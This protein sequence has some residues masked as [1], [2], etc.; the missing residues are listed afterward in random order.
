MEEK[1]SSH[2][3]G[4]MI[5]ERK[6]L[7]EEREEY[8][9]GC[10]VVA[11]AP[12]SFFWVGEHSVMY[13]QPALIQTIPIYVYVG[14]EISSG[15]DFDAEIRFV[16]WT[17]STGFGI[18]SAKGMQP[19][20]T[21]SCWQEWP[22]I[23]EFLTYWADNSKALNIR[24]A[25]KVW[26]EIPPKCGLNSS[27]AISSALAL[28]LKLLE[29]QLKSDPGLFKIKS[30]ISKWHASEIR[31]LK[32]DPLFNEL[33]LTAWVL[34]DCFHFFS[35]SGMGP[36][37]SL[38]GS[39]VQR[40]LI[41]FI[42][43]QKGY[44]SLLPIKRL[45]L[46]KIRLRPAHFSEVQKK[47]SAIQYWGNR[48]NLSPYMTE[49][50]GICALYTGD[51]KDTGKLLEE[52]E[53][54][55]KVTDEELSK[56]VDEAFDGQLRINEGWETLSAP[57]G[58]LL[59]PKEEPEDHPEYYSK[60][61][62]NQPNGLLAIYMLKAL[63]EE[64]VD[65]IADAVNKT[66]DFLRFYGA[67]T[68]R[69]E[70]I[71]TKILK[72]CEGNIG[73]KLTGAGGGGDLIV[74]GER[75][76]VESFANR[77]RNEYA[78]HYVTGRFPWAASVGIDKLNFSKFKKGGKELF[79]IILAGKLM[80]VD[81]AQM[82]SLKKDPSFLLFVDSVEGEIYSKG[83]KVYSKS[84]LLIPYLEQVLSHIEDGKIKYHTLLRHI[85]KEGIS[86]R[87]INKIHQF[88]IRSI[89]PL[90]GGDIEKH[91][92]PIPGKGYEITSAFRYALRSERVTAPNT[93]SKISQK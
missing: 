54:V 27:G 88:F 86:A 20:E 64:Q 40:S 47:V 44:G 46:T 63:G 70:R 59:A 89:F 43:Q 23:K 22:H 80:D 91:F 15:P 57:V 52:L 6:T 31:E 85:Y 58:H 82:V 81:K 3:R 90:A 17:Q 34:E 49:S 92:R 60:W 66:Y 16:S 8:F 65:K 26:C 5:A 84:G 41:T 13:G 62:I 10:Q 35:A 28:A 67:T 83:S 55:F 61:L 48:L 21:A 53:K 14:L 51:Y 30:Q 11:H 19:P 32:K 77:I 75:S 76:K 72:Q 36:F 93:E 12:A 9:E 33:F 71:R 25:V 42:T 74:I 29:L 73:V 87:G 56:I 18:L 7:Q 69:M 79:K 50:V 38:V 4:S 24:F 78:V 2:I 1:L 37:S 39:T 68:K 45:D